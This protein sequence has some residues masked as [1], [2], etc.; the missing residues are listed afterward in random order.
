M[1]KLQRIKLMMKYDLKRTL[2]ENLEENNLPIGDIDEAGM[3]NIAASAEDLTKLGQLAGKDLEVFDKALLNGAETVRIG[4]KDYNSWKQI[5]M[6]WP[7]LSKDATAMG[8][9]RKQ[10]ISNLPAGNA[11][12]EALIDHVI[13][14]EGFFKEFSGLSKEEISQ[15]LISKYPNRPDLTTDMANKF[16]AKDLNGDFNNYIAKYG[17]RA[18]TEAVI[19]VENFKKTAQTNLT[20]AENMT[21]ESLGAETLVLA[22][23]ESEVAQNISDLKV[24]NPKA[25]EIVEKNVA[26]EKKLTFGEK[27]DA[28]KTKYLSK[29]WLAGLGAVIGAGVIVRFLFGGN[30][31]PELN[32]CLVDLANTNDD[33]GGWRATSAGDPVFLVKQT[34]RYADADAKGGLWFFNT[35]RVVTADKG[36]TKRGTFSC[37]GGKVALSEQSAATDRLGNIQITWDGTTAKTDNNKKTQ[38]DGSKYQ[39]CNDFPFTFGCKNIIITD[40]QKCLGLEAKYQTG[41]FGPMTKQKLIDAKINDGTSITLDDFNK[42][43]TNCAGQPETKPQTEPQ[44]VDVP[45]APIVAQTTQNEPQQTPVQPTSAPVQPPSAPEVTGNQLYDH[46]LANNYFKAGKVGDQRVKY[47]GPDLTQSDLDKLNQYLNSQGYNF[48]KDKDKGTQYGTPDTEKYVWTKVR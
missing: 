36:V 35:G 6:D 41:N 17:R 30:T 10:L 16:I 22:K 44:K 11:T 42:I 25:A 46:Y 48:L 14:S 32:P 45:A 27:F 21:A 3:R 23:S 7:K 5:E 39:T 24:E 19:D 28:F 13:S 33:N 29:K 1:D 4:P 15:K 34:G 47:K 8:Q 20:A 26:I 43:R 2:N 38:T 31:T 12:R 18:G 40:I 37:S 9:L